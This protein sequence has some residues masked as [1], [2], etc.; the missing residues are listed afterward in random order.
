MESL[1][2]EIERIQE[3]NRRVELDKKW[4]TSAFRKLAVAMLTYFVIVL[5]FAAAGLPK[6]FVNAFVPTMGF[7]LSTLSL[8]AFKSVW[9][10][11]FYKEERLAQN[12]PDSNV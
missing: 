8:P 7:I 9:I 12:R 2:T 6:P 3:R 10:K 11:Y 1:Q 5:F 4:E